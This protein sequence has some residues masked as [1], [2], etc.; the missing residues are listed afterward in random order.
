MVAVFNKEHLSWYLITLKLRE[1][2]ESGIPRTSASNGLLELLDQEQQQLKKQ[3]QTP[4][5]SNI[6]IKDRDGTGDQ[7]YDEDQIISP[8]ESD[9]WVISIKEKLNQ[10]SQDDAAG[11]WG[12]LSIYKVPQHLRE[13]DY[14]HKAYVPQIV[15]LGPYHHGK[16]RLRQMDRYK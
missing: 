3:Q 14:D 10:A 2:V 13:G 8:S 12:K 6:V 11:T 5:H 16:K 7:N 4:S 1:T 15:S 9:Q